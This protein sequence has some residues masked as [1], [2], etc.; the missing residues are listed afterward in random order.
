MKSIQIGFKQFQKIDQELNAC[1]VKQ[2]F[3]ESKFY[4]GMPFS[5][6]IWGGGGGNFVINHEGG[7]G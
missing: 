3:S 5:Y 1:F 2:N 7:R 4:C 6:C